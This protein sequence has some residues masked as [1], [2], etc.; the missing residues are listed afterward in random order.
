MDALLLNV[1][2][3]E[4]LRHNRGEP[5]RPL[6]APGGLAAWQQRTVS[7]FIEAHIS[8]QLHITTLAD[9]VETRTHIIS[10]ERSKNLLGFRP[11]GIT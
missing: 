10:V 8:Q 6:P 2:K 9:L 3:A 7:D 1:L 11:T 4:I 5:K